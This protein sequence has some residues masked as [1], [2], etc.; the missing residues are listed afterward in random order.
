MKYTPPESPE[1]KR[2]TAF[3]AD[4]IRNSLRSGKAEFSAFLNLRERELALQTAGKL[5]AQVTFFGGCEDAERVMLGVGEP[6][7]EDFP[8]TPLDFAVFGEFDHRDVLGS[9]L[10]LG[11]DRSAVGDIRLCDG[12]FRVYVSSPVAD[13]IQSELVRVGRAA[14]KPLEGGSLAFREAAFEQKSATLA[15]V[16]LDG[17]VAAITDLSRADATQLITRGLVAVNHRVV[18]K[19]TYSPEEGDVLSVRGKGKFRIDDLGG[20]SRKGRV[21]VK[22]SKYL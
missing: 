11:L 21:I 14:A 22:Y 5:S 8:I 19:G 2:F 17:I 13:F 15:S 12:G 20:T 1:E 3:I 4:R 7:E 16:R 6:S 18:E 10:G 9:I